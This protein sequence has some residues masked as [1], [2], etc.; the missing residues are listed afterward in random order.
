M[1]GSQDFAASR[2]DFEVAGEGVAVDAATGRLSIDTDRLRA[3]VVVTVTATNALGRTVSRLRLTLATEAAAAPAVVVGPALAGASGGRGV[4]DVPVTLDPG[5]WEG[6]PAPE[7]AIAWLLDGTVVAGATGTGYTP[8]AADEG[9][10]LAARVTATNAAGAASAETATLAIVHAAPTVVAAL[11]DVAADA[12]AAPVAVAAAAAFAGSGAHVRR[13]RDGGDDRLRDRARDHRH[14]P[15][16]RRRTDHGD[17]NEL[18]RQRL[19][20]LRGDGARDAARVRD[21]AGARGGVRRQG[22]RRHAVTLD[23]GTWD[24]VPAPALAIAWLLDGAVVA[25]ATGPSYAPAAADEGKALAARVTATNAAG[26]A[27]AETAALAVVHAA[28]TVVAPLVDLGLFVGDAAAVVDAA[29]AFAGSALVF[30]VEGGGATVD[31]KGQV[32]VPATAAGSATVT[33]TATNSGGSATV[34]FVATVAVRILPPVLVLAPVLAGTGRIGEPVT[35]STGSWSGVP[36]PTTSVA[37]LRDGVAI[38]GATGMSYTPVAADDGKS[39]SARVTATNA[40]GSAAIVTAALAVTY[41]P[42]VAKGALHEVI[43][44]LGS[45]VETVAARADFTGE[46]LSFA[47]SGAGATIDA[48]TGLVSIPT[49]KAVQATVTV[50]ATNSGGSATSSFQVTVEAE[51]IPFALEAE[52]VEIAASIWRPEAQE[53][54]LTPVV[55]F[56]GLAGETVD[57]I[58]WTTSIKD[59]IPEAEFEVVAKAGTGHQLYMRDAAKNVPG[60]SPRVDYSVFKLDEKRRDMLRFRWRRTAEGPWS[61]LSP[62]YSV[63]AVPAA[64]SW[65]AYQRFVLRSEAQEMIGEAGGTCMQFPRALRRRRRLRPHGLRRDLGVGEHELRR[66]LDLRGVRRTLDEPDLFGRLRRREVRARRCSGRS[67]CRT[68]P[69]SYDTKGGLY[70]KDRETGKWTFT[71][72]PVPGLRVQQRRERLNQ[73]YIAKVAGSG[74][75]PDTRTL[76]AMYAPSTSAG[77]RFTTIQI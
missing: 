4:V 37:W 23:P 14:R 40:G 65:P 22:R 50:T 39:L 77:A 25:G 15:A 60:A 76:Y 46:N 41:A 9:K 8:A 64:A 57:A 73:R 69:T 67:S 1:D 71:Q 55:R 12:G 43:A 2:L 45:D 63:P 30:A 53:T 54:W 35:V 13:E 52:D 19:G 49:D 11:A 7:L 62:A 17:G 26:A 36:A 31:A 34:S 5:T 66:R 10:S 70:R 18:R 68:R 20:L 27:S 42:P 6:V 16:P 28:P 59:P 56:P 51:G 38:V 29:A 61:G 48:K 32:S 3:G 74:S 47:V 75:G 58:E 44:D 24:G 21:A 33:V 72:G